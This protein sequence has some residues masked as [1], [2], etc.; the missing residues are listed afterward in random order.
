MNGLVG[1]PLSVGGLGPRPPWAPLNPAMPTPPKKMAGINAAELL[2]V[3]VC[4]L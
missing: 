4:V 1:G 3:R 2:C